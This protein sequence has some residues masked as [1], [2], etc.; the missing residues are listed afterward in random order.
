MTKSAKR[1]TAL[2]IGCSA[3][4]YT[5]Q[6]FLFHDW[7]DT[8]FYMLQDWAFLPIQIALVTIIVGEIMNEHEKQERLEKT[9]ILTSSFFSDFGTELISLMIPKMINF[10]SVAANI[11]MNESW[12]QKEFDKAAASIQTSALQ[13]AC[14]PDDFRQIKSL[15]DAKRM[16][17][18][19]IAS[20]PSLL[21]HERF[22]DM[23]WA[24]FHL[25]DELAYRT[26]LDHLSQMDLLQL[27]VDAQRVLSETLVN[28]ICHLEFLQK[29]YPYLFQLEVHRNPFS[30]S[31][32]STTYD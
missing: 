8:A 30:V 22:T 13:L 25:N 23:L 17:L 2:L 27:N 20:N 16:T 5:L 31:S 11:A 32:Q 3:A 4:I 29:E 18:L 1:I 19:V 21:D 12:T 15:L 9:R 6:L 10:P 28:W 26:D 24:L 7:K 14:S